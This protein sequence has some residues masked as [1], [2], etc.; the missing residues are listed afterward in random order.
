MSD[1]LVITA[2]GM[3]SPLGN[4]MNGCAAAR[5]GITRP[6]HLSLSVSLEDEVEP[7]PIN[8]HSCQLAD[9]FQAYGRLSYLAYLAVLD[10]IELYPQ[11]D[12]TGVAIVIAIPNSKYRPH[13]D[14]QCFD[15]EKNGLTLITNFFGEASHGLPKSLNDSPIYVLEEG[16]TGLGKAMHVAGKLILKNGVPGCLI[17]SMD[18]LIEE[19]TLNEFVLANRIK[20]PAIPHGFSPSEAASA[21]FIEPTSNTHS[22]PI[23]TIK[24]V[25]LDNESYQFAPQ[26][27]LAFDDLSEDTEQFEEEDSPEEHEVN[28]TG[29]VYAEVVSKAFKLCVGE[30]NSWI[31]YNDLNGEHFKASEWGQM[32]VQL[33]N[34]SAR[35][36]PWLSPVESFGYAGLATTDLC[37]CMYLH[38]TI[39]NYTPQKHAVICSGADTGERLAIVL[40]K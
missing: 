21:F 18:S 14:Q 26:F 6:T 38:G 4:L 32:L 36:F 24:A 35:S 22:A 27:D 1:S 10:L 2:A 29:K 7:S 12:F 37:I 11:T 28:P 40:T 25:I 30:D 23:A 39:R 3:A 20:T 16:E 33:T 34:Q 5:A 31:G 19:S 17:I 15:L 8:G 13:L 9:G